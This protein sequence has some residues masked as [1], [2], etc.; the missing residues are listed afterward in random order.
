MF[1]KLGLLIAW[2]IWEK[3]QTPACICFR[4]SLEASHS[5]G[6][7]PQLAGCSRGHSQLHHQA[8]QAQ[9]D[10]TRPDP[11]SDQ[12]AM[13]SAMQGHERSRTGRW[14]SR[15]PFSRMTCKMPMRMA[16]PSPPPRGK[17]AR[18]MRAKSLLSGLLAV[19]DCATLSA[20]PPTESGN[21]LVVHDII[22]SDFDGFVH[23]KGC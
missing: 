9:P 12:Q 13:L 19:R 11:T 2:V 3:A 6:V 21:C 7:V 1:C 5:A 14:P 23:C 4:C 15:M 10:Q 20:Q 16:S 17:P 18:L 22:R 8:L